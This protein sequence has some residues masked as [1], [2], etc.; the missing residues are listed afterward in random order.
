MSNTTRTIL[1]LLTVALMLCWAL[2]ATT[3]ADEALDKSFEA[4][5]TYEWGTDRGVLKAIDDAVVASHGNVGAREELQKRL[6]AALGGDVPH[7]AKDYICRKLSLIGTGNCVST[8][9]ALLTDEKLSHMSRYALERIPADAAVA[10]MRDALPKV[11]GKTKVGVINSLGVRR[12]AQSAA[13][14]K[15][16]L[17]DSDKEIAAAAAAALGS[18]GNQDA[19]KALAAFVKSAPDGLKLAA[20]DAYLACAEQLLAAGKKVDALAI[21]KALNNPDQPDHVQI[22]A[23][24]GLLAA[25]KSN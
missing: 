2:P 24:R 20:A 14:L 15:A 22:A 12:D 10:A 4:L 13:A 6:C 8:V 9:A 7:A 17:G 23:K 25:M 3:L 18:I 19:A 21:Y 5:K 16:L 11:K 1:G